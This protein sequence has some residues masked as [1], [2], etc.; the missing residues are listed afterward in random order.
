MNSSAQDVDITRKKLIIKISAVFLGVLVLLTF[1]SNTIN[2]F[3]LPRVTVEEPISG[4][5]NKDVTGEGAVEEKETVKAYTQS[6]RQVLEVYT[7]VGSKVKKGDPIMKLD[8][9]ALQNTLTQE[10]LLLEKSKLSLEKLVNSATQENLVSYQ[11][12]IKAAKDKMLQAEKNLKSVKELYDIGAEAKANFDKAQMEY[13][14]AKEEYEYKQEDYNTAVKDGLKTEED[15][16]RDI[17]DR[18]LDIQLQQLKVNNIE[19]ELSEESKI[20]SPCDGIIKEIGFEKGSMTNSGTP[21]YSIIDTSKGFQF[22]VPVDTDSVKLLKLK[23]AVEITLNASD[24]KVLEGK[25]IEIKENAQSQGE[26]KD[27][28]ISL[29]QENLTSGE[30]GEI[31]INIKSKNYEILVPNS[32]VGEDEKGKFVYVL[33]VKKGPL[34]NENYVQR[35][36]V[37][38]VDHDNYR[39]AVTSGLQSEE[40][41][42]VS[43]SKDTLSDGCRVMLDRG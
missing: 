35:A 3:S 19:K 25:L 28:I 34:G 30:A 39:S 18:E 22:R 16:K 37:T 15:R 26:K 8:K 38:I 43:T 14:S 1:F 2:N 40:E 31:R 11:R 13:D 6:S 24:D 27:L 36:Y 21:L 42:I 23:D 12:S 5:L 20:V 41:I 9:Q 10:L 17:K 33:K 4:G 29:P 32:T 7:K